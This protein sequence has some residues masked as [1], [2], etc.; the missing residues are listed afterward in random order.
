MAR[1]SRKRSTRKIN[2]PK[3]SWKQVQGQPLGFIWRTGKHTFQ[4]FR[5]Y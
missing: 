5:T 4:G 1:R 3:V 2:R